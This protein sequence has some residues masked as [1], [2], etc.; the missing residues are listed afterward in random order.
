MINRPL[1]TRKYHSARLKEFGYAVTN[2]FEESKKFNEI[3]ALSDSQ[4]QKNNPRRT[5]PHH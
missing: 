3:V 2:T 4:M 5:T 1:Y